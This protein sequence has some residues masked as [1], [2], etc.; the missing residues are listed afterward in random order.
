MNFE[1]LNAKICGRF[2]HKLAWR[3]D[4][5]HDQFS[6]A[7]GYLSLFIKTCLNTTSFTVK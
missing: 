1:V 7:C 2:D 6:A 3:F 5:T 4:E